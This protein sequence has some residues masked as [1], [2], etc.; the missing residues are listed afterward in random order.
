MHTIKL[1]DKFVA[2]QMVAAKVKLNS[3]GVEYTLIRIEKPFD[4]ANC[5]YV[6]DDSGEVTIPATD[7]IIVPV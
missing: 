6:Y 7:G 1:P 5:K 4:L 3:T 2:S